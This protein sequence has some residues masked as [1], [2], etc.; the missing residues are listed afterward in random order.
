MAAL[1]MP[2][3]GEHS[4]GEWKEM[5][6]DRMARSQGRARTARMSHMVAESKKDGAQRSDEAYMQ[7]VTPAGQV[8]KVGQ[9]ATIVPAFGARVKY[10]P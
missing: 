2:Q 3:V 1:G 7:G 6:K 8:C 5:T 9:W 10:G 4:K